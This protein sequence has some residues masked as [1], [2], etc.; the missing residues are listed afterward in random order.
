MKATAGLFT[1]I[2]CLFIVFS[3]MEAK[4]GQ[5]GRGRHGGGAARGHGGG[6]RSPGGSAR[7]NLSRSPSMSRAQQ[8]SRA[9]QAQLRSAQPSS[10][11]LSTSR[12]QSV[13]PQSRVQ[14]QQFLNSHKMSDSA[15]R[16]QIQQGMASQR[17]VKAGLCLGCEVK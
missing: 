9:S 7:P 5:G 10:A 17:P 11:L 6:A 4:D 13:R 8:W 12:N 14:L 2:L 3:I 16:S 15:M 1:L